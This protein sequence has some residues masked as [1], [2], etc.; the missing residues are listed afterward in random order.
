MH[1]LEE[2]LLSFA[3]TVL[4]HPGEAKTPRELIP[5]VDKVLV[6]ASWAGVWLASRD[7][8][9]GKPLGP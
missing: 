9:V 4:E 8:L 1:R 2:R 7:A 5:L 6:G 3:R